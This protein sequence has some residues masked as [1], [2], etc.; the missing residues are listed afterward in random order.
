MTPLLSLAGVSKSFWRGT[1]RVEVLRR[2]SLQLAPGDF[3]AVTG[4][5]GSGKT[6]LLRLAAGLDAPDDGEVRFDGRL[7]T[8]LT[9][10][11]LQELRRHEIGYADRSGPFERELAALDHIAF[12]LM[13]TMRRAAAS[14]RA[15]ETMR[16]LGLEPACGALRWAELTDGERTLVSLAHAIV[17]RPKLLLVDDPTSNLGIYESERTTALLHQLAAEQDMAI[18]MAAPNLADTLRA[19]ELQS[20]CA[21]ELIGSTPPG[22]DLIRLPGA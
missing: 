4:N 15:M 1:V 16:Q 18:L 10:R 2:V 8:E 20:L 19:H 3:V 7:L 14:R 17:R 22:G 9:R 12:P 6:T 11:E 5:L 13:G 21:G